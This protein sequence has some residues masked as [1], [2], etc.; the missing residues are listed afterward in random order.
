[1]V[2]KNVLILIVDCS[3]PQLIFHIVFFMKQML[4]AKIAH[5][6][7]SVRSLISTVVVCNIRPQLKQYKNF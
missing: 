5:I 1:V 6:V 7:F 2:H 4:H 3:L